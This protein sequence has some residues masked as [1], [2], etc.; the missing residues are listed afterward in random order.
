MTEVLTSPNKCWK[1]AKSA[2]SLHT[3]DPQHPHT[4][5]APR[6]V[7]VAVSCPLIPCVRNVGP[8]CCRTS[9]LSLPY[10]IGSTRLHCYRIPVLSRTGDDDFVF[11]LSHTQIL[12]CGRYASLSAHDLRG[13]SDPGYASCPLCCRLGGQCGRPSSARVIRSICLCRGHLHNAIAQRLAPRC[14]VQ[15]FPGCRK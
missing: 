12:L 4:T 15:P 8:R 14:H 6:P 1:C 9:R 13:G 7:C 10:C 2:K 3:A 11:Q 5:G